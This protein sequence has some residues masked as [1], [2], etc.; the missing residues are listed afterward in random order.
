VAIKTV[1]GHPVSFYKDNDT[2]LVVQ[3]TLSGTEEQPR[4]VLISSIDPK[5]LEVKNWER[6]HYGYHSNYNISHRIPRILSR[7][8]STTLFSPF[9]NLLKK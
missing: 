5:T 6:P 2:L 1:P 7:V 8:N 3:E 4:Q 9:Q